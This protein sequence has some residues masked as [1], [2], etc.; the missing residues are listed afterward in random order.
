MI[1]KRF[2]ALLLASSSFVWWTN[3][4]GEFV[5]EQPCWRAF[6]GQTWEEYR[7]SRWVSCLHP[8]DRDSIVA[9]WT[10]TVAKGNPYF[11]QG[12][13][14]SARYGAYRAFQMRGIPIRNERDEVV[15]W[16]GALT[17][18]QDT[19]EFKVLLRD[20]RKDLIETLQAL[21]D[22]EAKSPI[23]AE[24]LR[25]VSDELSTILNTAGIGIT[26]CSRELRY[27]RANETYATIAGLPLDEIIGRPIVEVMGEAAFI[28]IR[29]YIERVL[30]GE[31][32]EYESEIPFRNG[33]EWCSYRVVYVPDQPDGSVIAGSS[34]LRT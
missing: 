28:T 25:A 31:R 10:R 26:R 5:K 18:V 2:D 4:V 3:A 34:M 33:A 1:T 19:I 21:R 6:T 29:P 17:D 14:W 15:E 13:I 7:G 23:R 9:E 27:L 16:F 24:Q 11:T 12:R 32:V 20:A 8:D 30:A 22:S